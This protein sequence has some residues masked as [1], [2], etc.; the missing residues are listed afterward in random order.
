MTDQRERVSTDPGIG[1]VD[2][3]NTATL[4]SI[5][6]AVEV[7]PDGASLYYEP[8]PLRAVSDHRTL[9]METVKLSQE[10]DPRKLPTEISLPRSPIP[11][12]YDSGWPQAD[13]VLTS[14]Q[15]PAPPRRRWRVPALLFGVLVA[16]LMLVLARSAAQHAAEQSAA[17][18]LR[19][20]TVAPPA[21]VSKSVALP[22]P[23]PKP[24]ALP[25]P[26]LSAALPAAS[27]PVAAASAIATV[28]AVPVASASAASHV[29]A[30][31][32]AA[33]YHA[34]PKPSPAPTASNTALS[35]PTAKPKRAI[36]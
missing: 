34:T 22:A 11:P 24:V 32:V 3:D 30:P 31:V 33:P 6:A 19:V 23:P 26:A 18:S 1:P 35:A 2:A 16:L 9:E 29:A 10:I 28:I 13:L 12:R 17:S 27:V 36:Y 14:S 8:L 21:L 20:E 7:E 4:R 15:R 25:A 5:E